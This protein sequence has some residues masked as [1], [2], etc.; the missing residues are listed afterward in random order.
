[1]TKIASLGKI[2][3]LFWSFRTS[4]F[5]YSTFCLHFCREAMMLAC[6]KCGGQNFVKSGKVFGKQRYAAMQRETEEF[7]ATL[8]KKKDGVHQKEIDKSNV[9]K[10]GMEQSNDGFI[11][12]VHHF[13][14]L[15]SGF[16]VC[17]K[18]NL[19]KSSSLQSSSIFCRT[20]SALTTTFSPGLSGASKLNSSSKRS[21]I[22]Y[23][24]RAPMF[25]IF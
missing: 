8:D 16:C 20:Y 24:R 13:A 25:C 5:C 9:A 14:A 22:V 3:K 23:K 17:Y 12:Y 10:A 2:G 19:L 11:R 7:I 15:H 4:L 1:M 6:K 21:I 18:M